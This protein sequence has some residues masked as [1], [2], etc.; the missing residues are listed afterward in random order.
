MRAMSSAVVD[1]LVAVEDP[2]VGCSVTCIEVKWDDVAGSER[3][4][5]RATRGAMTALRGRTW[6]LVPNAK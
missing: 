3:A 2:H 4:F 1:V 5:Y 6:S